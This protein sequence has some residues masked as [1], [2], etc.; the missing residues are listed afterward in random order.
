[1]NLGNP[2]LLLLSILTLPIGGCGGGSSRDSA[3]DTPGATENPLIPERPALESSNLSIDEE[4]EVFLAVDL[5][6]SSFQGFESE[7][8][9][10]SNIAILAGDEGV[11]VHTPSVNSPKIVELFLTFTNENSTFREPISVHVR[12]TSAE[13]LEKRTQ[14]TIDDSASLLGLE[15]DLA[16]YHF[17]VDTAYLNGVIKHSEKS[18][19]MEAFVP[20]HSL[21]YNL[22]DSKLSELEASYSSYNQGRI[23]DIELDQL[24][25]QIEILAKDH[26]AYGV[27]K[28]TS[29]SHFSEIFAP[30]L[31]AGSLSFSERAGFFS[32]FVGNPVYG[33]WNGQI[34]QLK[35]P[36]NMI[37]S[38]LRTSLSQDVLCD[39]I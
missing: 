13:T 34:F 9:T 12:N 19:L 1:M 6:G 33:D 28:L 26:G 23:A 27:E 20:E 16:L 25:Q 5:N 3:T 10:A 18:R 38:L 30:T 11:Y 36:Y 2:T 7:T 32:R 31:T 15:Q 24:I 17:A 22:L 14:Q 8:G 35:P 37:T 29:V 21:A 39:A 4:S